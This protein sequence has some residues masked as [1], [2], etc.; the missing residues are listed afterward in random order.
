[1][2]KVTNCESLQGKLLVAIQ[3][4]LGDFFHHS[5]VL[6]TAHT[7]DFAEGLVLNKPLQPNVRQNILDQ[8]PIT[9]KLTVP[10]IWQGGPVDLTHGA[11]LH[12]PEYQ[13]PDTVMV[14]DDIAL[15]Q[16]HQILQ[17]IAEQKAP[18]KFLFC[19][20]HA[21]WQ[22]HQ[23]EEEIM[24]NIWIPVSADADLVFTTPYEKKWQDALATLQIDTARFSLIAGK[25]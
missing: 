25:S 16:T 5:V 10:T 11:I 9:P 2:P 17:D 4:E 18:E 7:S 14:T 13:T 20:G 24:G 15:T 3:T 21:A 23:L 1:M 6:L 12:S 19:V 8:L 22:A